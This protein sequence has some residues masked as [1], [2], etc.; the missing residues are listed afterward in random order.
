VSFPGGPWGIPD[1]TVRG[2]TSS[3]RIWARATG[4][5]GPGTRLALVLVMRSPWGQMSVAGTLVM[6]AWSSP[7]H[8]QALDVRGDLRDT[9][10]AGAPPQA[11]GEADEDEKHVRKQTPF[12][13]FYGAQILLSDAGAVSILLTATIEKNLLLAGLGL[14][15][16]FVMPPVLHGL[17]HEPVNVMA[18]VALRLTIPGVLFAYGATR[19]DDC[20]RQSEPG[21]CRS[22]RWIMPVGLSAIGGL[23]ASI[24]DITLVAHE[25]S[26]HEPRVHVAVLPTSGGAA[27]AMG[28]SF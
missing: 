24:L 16:F 13:Q 4:D 27:L 15:T 26:R 3:G 28:G 22:L 11:P 6:L 8:A 23:A 19:L 5:L 20:S 1:T 14:A 9:F 25:R 10:E 17:H 21:E 18:S 12:G 7:T 2:P